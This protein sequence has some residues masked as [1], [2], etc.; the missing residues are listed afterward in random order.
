MKKNTLF[1]LFIAISYFNAQAQYTANFS[2]AGRGMVDWT[3]AAAGVPN[4]TGATASN[5][6]AN[7][8]QYN[9]SGMN[10][11]LTGTSTDQFSFLYTSPTQIDRSY[12]NTIAGNIFRTNRTNGDICMTSPIL[13]IAGLGAV[14]INMS[15]FRSGN[16]TGL[17]VSAD[18]DVEFKYILNG[19]AVVSSGSL[20]GSAGITSSWTQTV[21]GTTL[22]IFACMAQNGNTEQ[23]DLTVFNT[24]KGAVLPITLSGF[25]ANR[26]KD[27]EVRVSWQTAVEKNNAYFDIERSEDGKTF[28]SIGEVKGKGNTSSGFSYSFMDEKPA[29][30]NNYYRLKQTDYDGS[31]EYSHILTV[32]NKSKEDRFVVAPNPVGD[33]LNIEYLGRNNDIRSIE[34]YDVFGKLLYQVSNDLQ[35]NEINTSNLQ[36]GTYIWKI[37]QNGNIQTGKF[38]KI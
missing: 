2:V 34:I 23:Y 15:V 6:P 32:N 5:N 13:D 35:E 20:T 7:C 27:N 14:T 11:T 31:F 25:F 36:S 3:G 28:R 9:V 26:T 30:G 8:G 22:Q 16:G 33:I 38:L 21:T 10:W 17:Y 1:L 37:N 4:C 19:G 24:N 29:Q 12:A 18:D